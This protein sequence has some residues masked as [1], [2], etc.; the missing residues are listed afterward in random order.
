MSFQKTF[1]PISR[2]LRAVSKSTF[3]ISV[4]KLQ[5][6][7]VIGALSAGVQIFVIARC[8]GPNDYG[9]YALIT[10]ITFTAR[11]VFD[12]RSS[13]IIVKYYSQFSGA[14]HR[15]KRLALFGIAL[16]IEVLSAGLGSLSL[17][18]MSN[19]IAE[20]V[21]HSGELI[22]V[23]HIG[24]ALIM[25]TIGGS[26]ARGYLAARMAFG[27]IARA[28][29][30]SAIVGLLLVLSVFL[31]HPNV[32]VLLCLSIIIYGSQTIISCGGAWI[33]YRKTGM[34]LS[35]DDLL[36]LSRL[37][38]IGS[39]G[40]ELIRFAIGLNVLSLLKLSQRNLAPIYLGILLSPVYAGYYAL[41]QRIV[42]RIDT[43]TGAIQRVNY[44]MF[45]AAITKKDMS[46]IRNIWRRSILLTVGIASPFFLVLVPFAP[47][48][49]PLV[50]GSDYVKAIGVFQIV[51][52]GHMIG[53][54]TI[55][56]SYLLQ[57]SGKIAVINVAYLTG[58]VVQ[59]ISIYFLTAGFQALGAAISYMALHCAMALVI[60]AGV[61][62]LGDV[63]WKLLLYRESS[64][65][66]LWHK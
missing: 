54:A 42:G 19:W 8:L 46:S 30:T 45:T 14:N 12:S 5:A 24:A 29:I 62:K 57:A 28:D 20:N 41:A 21:L 35:H 3:V 39:R 55:P 1:G 43:F 16:L 61:I 38:A 60:F 26:T 59:A 53:L 34:R 65:Y 11:Q 37:W 15:D 22:G 36:L 63:P 17:I 48:F 50:F 18:A 31:M 66:K 40:P 33:V 13:D 56:S 10:T 9:I 27:W 44:P 51:M 49:V 7:S 52:V 6:S 32:Y 47:L 4:G 58:F 23:V 2:M 64:S 25:V